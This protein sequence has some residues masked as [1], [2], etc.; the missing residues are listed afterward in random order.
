MGALH[1]VIAVQGNSF[2]TLSL[3]VFDQCQDQLYADTFS[4]LPRIDVHPF[5]FTRFVAAR[6][7]ATLPTGTHPSRA[8][9]KQP[10]G[11]AYLPGNEANSTPISSNVGASA[12]SGSN[13]MAQ[14]VKARTSYPAAV[15]SSS[16]EIWFIEIM[17]SL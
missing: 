8:S 15:I 16:A 17:L 11:G 1:R 2:C 7:K 5:P 9:E 14:V 12:V 3:C 13:E 4:A 10:F 6:K